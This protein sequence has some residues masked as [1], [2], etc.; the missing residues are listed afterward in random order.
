[1][2]AITATEQGFYNRLQDIS[3][4]LQSWFHVRLFA[5]NHVNGPRRGI[6]PLRCWPHRGLL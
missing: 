3:G 5:W 2:A 4:V 6:G 1:L